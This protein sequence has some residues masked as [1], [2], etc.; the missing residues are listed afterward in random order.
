[1]RIAKFSAFL[2]VNIS[3]LLTSK[4]YSQ[5]TSPILIESNT[6]LITNIVTA[7]LNND[8][9]LDI[10]VTKKFSSTS[11]I[12]YY[13][14]QGDFNFGPESIIATGSSQ[15]T[16]IAIGDFNNDSWL[17]IVSIGD[18][19]NSVT[20]YMNNALSFSS[21][22]IDSFSFFES[23]L[24][25]ADIDNDNQL[26]IIAIGG[27]TLKVYY[28]DGAANFT[29]QTVVGPIE[30]FFDIT[31]ADI[32]ADGF[33]DVVTGGS[34]ISVYKNS[35]GTLIYDSIR[36]NQIPSSFNLFVR[37]ADIDNDGD[38]DLF[39]EGNNSTGIR[40]VQNDGNGNF[41]NV[42]MIDSSAMN[43]RTGALMDYDNDN[44]L[45]IFILKDFNVFFYTNEGA[46]NF[47]APVLVQDAQTTISVLEAADFNNDS[48]IDIIWSADLSV[49][50]NN[51][52][53]SYNPQF[54]NPQSII[55]YPNPTTDH[56]YIDIPQDGILTILT[57]NGQIVHKDL[58][59]KKGLNLL[60]TDLKPQLY[61]FNIALKTEI[62]SKKI[63]I[64]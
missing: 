13:L 3:I 8:S 12:S 15:V 33:K 53:L 48:L 20:L 55:L 63:L 56:I 49:Q 41:S 23:D 46:G 37:L 9:L 51:L 42:Q 18:V 25:V 4:L 59:L 31:I 58:R 1:M 39:S 26:D 61:L 45:D 5:F 44:D 11:L 35:G 10:I 38:E 64:K 60:K 30:D 2:I 29:A 52:T 40:W 6:G 34:N 36:S 54:V 14:N 43:I 16:N 50:V 62:I 47:S 22:T 7:D 21:Q 27:T 24:G 28:N 57:L 19:T 32:D 17:D